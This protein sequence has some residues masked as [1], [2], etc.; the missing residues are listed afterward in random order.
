MSRMLDRANEWD[1]SLFSYEEFIEF[2][3]DRPAEERTGDFEKDL[4]HF[5]F[6][7]G[8]L[9]GEVQF[10]ERVVEHLT[11]LFSCFHDIAIR[12]SLRQINQGFWAIWGY[13]FELHKTLWN[14]SVELSKRME[15]IRSMYLVK[16]M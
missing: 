11:R 9:F 1:V 16:V 6:G 8:P 4:V 2:F 3:F 14:P 12:H 15:C 13:D 7:R 5:D 10:P